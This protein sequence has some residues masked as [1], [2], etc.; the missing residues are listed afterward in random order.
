[1]RI[2]IVEDNS[3]S[4][5]AMRVSLQNTGF[6][7]SEAID[8]ESAIN[9]IKQESLD[10]IVIDMRLP[11]TDGFTLIEQIRTHLPHIPILCVT[12]YYFMEKREILKAGFDDFLVKPFELSQLITM[13]RALLGGR[14][15][16]DH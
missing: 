10:L 11:D 7:V 2:L 3:V 6:F 16:A 1:M 14:G 9:L 13:C 12:A 15:S 5:K 4:R 8:G